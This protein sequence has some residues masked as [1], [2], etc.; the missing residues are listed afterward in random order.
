[1]LQCEPVSLRRR[2]R[3]CLLYRP[4]CEPKGLSLLLWVKDHRVSTEISQMPPVRLGPGKSINAI[5]K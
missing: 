1:M 2:L 3:H 5:L 4:F